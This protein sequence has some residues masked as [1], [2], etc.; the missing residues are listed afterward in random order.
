MAVFRATEYDIRM[1][2][3]APPARSQLR[4]AAAAQIR[5]LIIA[6]LA[7]PGELLR[8]APLAER[9]DASVTPVREALLLLAQD[10]WVVQEPNRGFRVAAIQRTDVEDAYVVHAFVAGELARRAAK[11]AT[12][13][14]IEKLRRLDDEIKRFD[15]DDEI[16]QRQLNY[17]LHDAVYAIANSPR[18]VLFV[19]AASRFVPRR[20]WTTIPGWRELNRSE[21]GPIIDAIERGDSER[22]GELMSAHITAAGQLLLAHLDAVGFWNTVSGDSA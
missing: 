4:D 5:E 10:G 19:T 17:E 22:A 15:G 14:S 2:A 12:P 11:L 9:I 18:L 21:H 8:L 7:R 13:E 6:G 20:Y 16:R 3:L 1:S